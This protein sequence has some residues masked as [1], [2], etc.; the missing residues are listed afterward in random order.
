MVLVRLLLFFISTIG[1]FELIRKASDDKVSIYFL[2]SLTIA[3]QVSV[4]FMAGLLNLL[5]EAVI[6]LYLIGF[7][8]IIYSI[9]KNRSL[10]FL[11]S[12][13]NPGYILFIALLLVF[14]VYLRGKVF[15]SFD[16]FSHWAL[17]VK[18]MLATDRYPNFKDTVIVFQ[19]YPLGSA[20]YIYYFAKLT[21]TSE[22]FQMLAQT[23]MMLAAILPLYSFAKKN[24][25]AVS[26][27][28]VSFVNYVFLYNSKI[29]ELYVDTL[30]PLA[31]ICGLLFVYQHCKECQKIMLCFAACYMVQAAQIKNYG[32]FFVAFIVIYLLKLAPKRDINYAVCAAAPFIS[33]LLWYKHCGYVYEAAATSSQAMTVEKFVSVFGNKSQEN[34]STICAKLFKSA[35]SYK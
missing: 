7:A 8:G 19:S 10:A 23:Y 18:Q 26:A 9:C 35:V 17:V 25:L 14:A 13:I 2:P 11:K 31:G 6:A 32:I 16:N 33:L 4:L 15:K 3:I 20:S 21:K 1:S 30:L 24:H 5:P 28:F 22:S 29:V 27:V 34:I 12:Y